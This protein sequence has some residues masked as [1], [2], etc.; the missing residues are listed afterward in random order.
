MAIYPKLDN[1][2]HNALIQKKYLL[3]LPADLN[4][5][6]K[7]ADTLLS[8]QQFANNICKEIEKL[9]ESIGNIGRIKFLLLPEVQFD[10]LI[11]RM[12]IIGQY[13]RLFKNNFSTLEQAFSNTDGK[14][15]VFL[16]KC[17]TILTIVA[18]AISEKSPL[19][20]NFSNEIVSKQFAFRTLELARQIF[21]QVY[22]NK[23]VI[24]LQ[25]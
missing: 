15:G 11:M 9:F 3:G 18:H 2:F 14:L 5:R 12:A 17:I 19:E 4:K 22:E 10:I 6:F 25:K 13:A 7:N 20:K 21:E 23:I 16:H 1:L 8:S 24:K